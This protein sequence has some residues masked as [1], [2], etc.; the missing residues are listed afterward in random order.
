MRAVN[1]LFLAAD[2]QHIDIHTR[3]D[4]A[5]PALHQ[6]RSST[7]ASW[8]AAPA[9]S[10]WAASWCARDAQKTDAQQTNK[11]LLLSREA[12]VHSVPQLEIL[13][14]DVKCK[15][16]STTGQ[17]DPAALFY[18]RSRGIGEDA[19]R[20]LLTYA[21]AS[22]IVQRIKVEP[23]RA[24]L[25][26]LP[27]R[28]AAPRAARSRRRWHDAPRPGPR[29]WPSVPLD[30][31]ARARATSPSSTSTVHGHPLVYLDNAASTQKPRPVIDAERA[32]YEEY[33][34]NIHRGVHQLS[35]QATDAYEGARAKVQRFLS[36]AV[37]EGD[38]LHPRHHRGHQP[39]GRRATAG[40]NVGA[41]DEVA[42]HRPR[43][44]LQHRPLAD[45]LRGEGRA[46]ARGAP[47]TTTA[48]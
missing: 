30:V 8:T 45:A 39:R 26:A 20:S 37:H 5:V 46:P 2:D 23:L 25:D 29:A 21:F 34:A 28:P 31:D 19:A 47:S 35:M 7:R 12:L 9:A 13:A 43:A 32:V 38:R 42:H 11:N 48:R 6:P 1:G 41:G 10:S 4:H 33:Y 16:G 15:H 40:A 44:P 22:D 24:G 18:L 3:V 17:L 36:A 27:A 14:D